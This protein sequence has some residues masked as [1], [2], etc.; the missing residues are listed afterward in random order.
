MGPPYLTR[1]FDRRQNARPYS[2]CDGGARRWIARDQFHERYMW[3]GRNWG[4]RAPSLSHFELCYYHAIDGDRA[5]VEVGRSRR[6]RRHKLARGYLPTPLIPRISAN[7]ACAAIADYCARAFMCRLRPKSLQRRPCSAKIWSTRT[8]RGIR[9]PA[10]TRT[11]FS[12]RSCAASC[13]V[14][15]STRMIRR[16]LFLTSCLVHRGTPSF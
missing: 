11:T 6:S 14:T 13:P 15:K 2:A 10:M 1:N 3:Y 16:L 9:S 12:P 7:P 5:S 4:N 8:E